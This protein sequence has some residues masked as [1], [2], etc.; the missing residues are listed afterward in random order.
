MPLWQQYYTAKVKI[1]E[2]C[3]TCFQYTDRNPLDDIFSL[4]K[5][6]Q[7]EKYTVLIVINSGPGILLCKSPNAWIR[8]YVVSLLK[9]EDPTHKSIK[10]SKKFLCANDTIK[11]FRGWVY[12]NT[13]IPLCLTFSLLK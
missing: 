4:A 9:R 5:L 2:N 8:S 3:K 1:L 11:T 6:L 7:L 10:L 12:F 13:I